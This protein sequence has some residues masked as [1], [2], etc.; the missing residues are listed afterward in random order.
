MCDDRRSIET[1]RR[2]RR[3]LLS[4]LYDDWR[5]WLELAAELGVWGGIFAALWLAVGVHDGLSWRAGAGWTAFW[6]FGSILWYHWW[7]EPRREHR[8]R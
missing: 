4:R 5:W 1:A 6:I 3:G 2:D 7:F 8:P